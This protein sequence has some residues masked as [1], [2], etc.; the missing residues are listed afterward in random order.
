MANCPGSDLPDGRST[1]RQT[2]GVVVRGKVADQSGGAMG[3]LEQR[4]RF[5]EKGRLAGA[6]ARYQANHKDAG[7]L[8]ARAQSVGDFIVVLENVAPDLDNSRTGNGPRTRNG[9]HAANS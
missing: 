6:G 8:K 3:A 2:R 4:K 1:A 5:F 7:L 9:A